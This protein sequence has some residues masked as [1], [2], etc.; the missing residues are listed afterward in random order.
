[1][2]I[3]HNYRPNGHEITTDGGDLKIMV[4]RKGPRGI[5]TMVRGNGPVVIWNN[6]EADSHIDDSEEDLIQKTIDVLNG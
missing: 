3:L 1:M 2:N 6:D 5:I 4:I